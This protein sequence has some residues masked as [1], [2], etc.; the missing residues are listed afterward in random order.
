LQLPAPAVE[1][2]GPAGWGGAMAQL[3]NRS[4]RPGEQIDLDIDMG[5]A[6]LIDPETDQVI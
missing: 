3:S 5:R 4:R 6:V 2:P 1:M